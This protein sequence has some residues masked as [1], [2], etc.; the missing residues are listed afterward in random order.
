MAHV[1]IL[2]PLLSD[3]QYVNQPL[4]FREGANPGNSVN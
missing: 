1:F 3:M 4:A 2:P